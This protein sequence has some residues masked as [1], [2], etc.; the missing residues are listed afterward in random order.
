MNIN[1]V[2]NI[3]GKPDATR[4]YSGDNFVFRLVYE[5]PLGYSDNIYIFVGTSDSLVKGIID[6]SE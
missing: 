5:P 1:E 4:K 6:G 3:M 2:F